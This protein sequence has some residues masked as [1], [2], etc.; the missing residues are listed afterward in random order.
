[1]ALN[2]SPHLRLAVSSFNFTHMDGYSFEI[3][4]PGEGN[5]VFEE[6]SIVKH[7]T[8]LGRTRHTLLLDRESGLFS[9]SSLCKEQQRVLCHHTDGHLEEKTTDDHSS[10]S[11]AS[12][13]IL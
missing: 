9:G 5:V 12:L 10:T 3:E 2:E 13:Y 11:F 8:N 4:R 7:V 6:M 1:M